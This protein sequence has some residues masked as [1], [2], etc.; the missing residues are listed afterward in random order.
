MA[1]LSFLLKAYEQD[2]HPDASSEA[3]VVVHVDDVN[4][5]PSFLS[6]HY[7]TSISEGV[8]MGTVLF[9][10]LAAVD[11]DEVGICYIAIIGLYACLFVPCH[12]DTIFFSAFKCVKSGL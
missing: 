1:L 12:E 9:T 3:T 2:Q 4:E 7:S 10:G 6:S 5:P 8:G 11:P